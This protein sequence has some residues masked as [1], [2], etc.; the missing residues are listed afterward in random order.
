MTEIEEIQ[1]STG[2]SVNSCSCST[3]KNMCRQQPCI[4]TPDDIKKLIDHGY[5]DRLLPTIWGSGLA[6]GIGVIPMIQIKR[7]DVGGCPFFSKEGLCELHDRGLKPTE[8]KL[9]SHEPERISSF[10]E[11][12]NYKTATTWTN[13]DNYEAISFICDNLG[14]EHG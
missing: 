9:C 5:K 10:K 1:K 2:A 8:G 12:I 6:F 7:L 13:N 3:C 4:G 14:I 11:S